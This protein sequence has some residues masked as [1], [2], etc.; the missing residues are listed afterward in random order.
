MAITWEERKLQYNKHYFTDYGHFVGENGLPTS[1]TGNCK[2]WAAFLQ[3]YFSPKSVLDCGCATGWLVHGLRHLDESIVAKGCDVSEFAITHSFLDIRDRLLQWDISEGLPYADG[4]FELVTGIDLLEHLQ[5]YQAICRAVKDMVRVCSRT[6]FLRQPMVRFVGFTTQSEMH[7][8]IA[9]LNPLPH[10]ARL[11]LVGVV[12][13][14]QPT[15]PASS[16]IEHP[17]EHPREFWIDLFESFGV[18]ETPLPETAYI[19]PNPQTVYS[20]DALVFVKNHQPEGA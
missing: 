20:F 15:A 6:I 18:R 14:L 8:Y 12:P 4:E 1:Q 13:E 11:A 16:N 3:E 2:V 19:F 17:S 7:N 9:T 10:R 5:D